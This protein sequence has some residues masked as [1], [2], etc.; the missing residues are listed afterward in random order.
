MSKVIEFDYVVNVLDMNRKI[1]IKTNYL[2]DGVF[3]N[4]VYLLEIVQN[5]KDMTTGNVEPHG[6]TRENMKLTKIEI[7]SSGAHEIPTVTYVLESVN[8][9]K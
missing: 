4:G 5:F 6:R 1:I 3:E 7:P 8:Q 9:L 2:C